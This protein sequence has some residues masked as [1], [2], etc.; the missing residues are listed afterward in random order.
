MA[1]TTKIYENIF[2]KKN[3]A[4]DREYIKVPY[5]ILAD[6]PTIP[7]VSGLMPKS[8]GTFTGEVKF[9]NT[10]NF[11]GYY[12][13]RM[14]GYLGAGTRYADLDSSYKDGTWHR[15]WRLR[16][17]SGSNFWG[18]IKITLYGG[19]SSFNASGVMSK[20]ITCNFNTSNI[21]NNVGCYD[22]LGV[23][24][25]Q[26]F[27]ISEAIWN[28]TASAWEVLIWQKNLNGNNSPVIM[29]ECWTTNNTT[30][31]NAFNGI[32]AQTV[33][34]T[35]STSYSAQRASSTGGT[36]TVMWATLPVYENPLGEEIATVAMLEDKQ[37]KITSSNKLKSSLVDGLGA[38][39][40]KAV[41]T[42]ISADSTSTNLPTSKAVE[43]RINAHSGIDK[44]GT[45]TGITMN[46]ESKGTS[47]VVD[48]G[49]VLTDESK[50]A[51]SAQGT[52]A[53][54]AMPKSGGAFTGNI[55]VPKTITFTDTTNPYIKMTTGGTDFYFQS[56]SGQ[57]GLGPTWN[58]A[59]HWDA[60]GNVTFPTTPKVG[61]SSLALKSEIPTNYVP[62]TRKVNN[63]ALSSDITLDASDVR[64]LPIAGGT[65]TG[66]LTV[67]G[68]LTVNGTTTTV[69]STTLQVKD[70][71][72]EVAH[73][74]TA[75][76]TTPAGLVA[77]KYDGTNS[78][79]LVFDSTGT[80]YV[81]DVTL[82]DGN[83]D[84]AKSGLQPLATRTG[85]VGGNLV[86]Y[87]SSALTL[88]DSGKKISDLALK[89][90]IPTDYVKYTEQTLTDAQKSQVRT[91]IGV[92]G[93][94][95]SDGSVK[96]V[97][98]YNNTNVNVKIGYS[99][100][101]I[102]GADIKYIA[103]YTVSDGTDGNVAR[104]KDISKDALKSWLGYATVAT[105]GSYD[106]LIKKPTIPDIV[107][108]T[109]TSTSSVMSQNATTNAISGKL[110]KTTYEV[111]KTINF[112][113]D[114]ALYIGK[115]KV[116]DTNVTCEVTSTT[117]VTYSGKLVIATQ[118]YVIA[119]MTVYGDAANTVAPNF[120]I[121]PSTTSDPYIEIYFK[122][123]SW[124]KNVVHIYGSAIEAEPTNVCTNVASVPSTATSKPTNALNSK[125]NLAGDNT[126]TGG[127]TITGSNGGYSINASGYIKGSW[128]QASVTDIN[129]TNGGHASNGTGRVCVFDGAGWIYYRTPEEVLLDGGIE[130]KLQNYQYEGPTLQNILFNSKKWVSKTWSGLTSFWGSSIWTDGDN[131]YHSSGSSQYVLNKDTS[132]WSEKTW[133]GLTNF[134]VLGIWTDGDNIYHSQGSSHYVLDKATSTWSKKTWS[135]LTSSTFY[136]YDIWTDGDN[137]YYSHGPTQYILNKATSTWSKKTW[138]GLTNFNGK[139]VWTDGDNIYYS[140]NSSTQ[141][142]LNK[143]TS[144]WSEKTWSGTALF[145]GDYIW[146]D[147][148]NIYYS[149]TSEASQYIL[150]KA[151]STW[152]KKT[153]SGGYKSMGGDNIWTDGDNIYYSQGSYHYVLN[154]V[155][156]HVR[157]KPSFN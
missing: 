150:N 151:T 113:R 17:P 137:I 139:Y 82:K 4:G 23:N 86:Q 10:E 39:A 109:G 35:Q 19:Y 102:T 79:A 142:V 16:F 93:F 49:T 43:D 7:D 84:V 141:Y 126:F 112:G 94:I 75:A 59:T 11:Q 53:D 8:G 138:S 83:I 48:L 127:Q 47:D 70:K 152:S 129:G 105:S 145:G 100:A 92:S 30:Y 25:E 91:N 132:T 131:I 28:A 130:K 24:V 64:A 27:R 148:D 97:I 62:N 65:V 118:N 90:D 72:I 156:S 54:N 78:G 154:K 68:N 146:T 31:I 20:S 26:D 45:I 104:I 89:T 149:G 56:T 52:K 58:K 36:K 73:G 63:K 34:L 115:F 71:L 147:G 85:L 111:N 13:K 15:M 57:F 50:F 22:G 18:K 144:T 77:P 14:L 76:L 143:D 107:Q 67:G 46:G 2:I 3:K 114:G 116:Y 110:D 153:W 122:P 121:K 155:K 95:T 108:T 60:N 124:S 38:A 103:G 12:I 136:A 74:N 120:F 87:D 69:D 29:L 61:S 41:D 21:Y 123:A 157:A 37:D 99:G 51:T 140:Y 98:D 32:T 1:D 106:D 81:G 135:G 96:S 42:T 66:N 44:V 9:G 33:E 134:T 5:A 6:P 101:G 128:L 133:S 40:A 119:K 55:S 125:A 117:N 88:K 80:A